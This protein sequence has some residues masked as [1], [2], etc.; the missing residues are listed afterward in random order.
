VESTSGHVVYPKA[1]GILHKYLS[2][3]LTSKRTTRPLIFAF[4]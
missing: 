2:Q 4:L 1:Q 3:M